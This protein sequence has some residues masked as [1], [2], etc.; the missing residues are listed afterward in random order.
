VAWK[1]ATDLNYT[2]EL[3]SLVLA[4]EEGI[5]GQEFGQNAAK[6]PHVDGHAIPSSDDDFR[7][8]VEAGL[9][10]RVD[11]LVVV[12]TRTEINHLE[13]WQSYCTMKSTKTMV[14]KNM[15]LLIGDLSF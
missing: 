11:P 1:H 15:L 10:V 7:R 5:S 2:G 3:I 9:D 12:A 6:A 14:R 4:T 13:T 8:T